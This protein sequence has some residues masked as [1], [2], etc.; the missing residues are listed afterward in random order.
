MYWMTLTPLGARF[1]AIR[2]LPAGDELTYDYSTY[3]I[4][5]DETLACRCKAPGWD[6]RDP[7]PASCHQERAAGRAGAAVGQA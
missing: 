7:P 1:V 5:D 2:D 6:G 3:L 4:D